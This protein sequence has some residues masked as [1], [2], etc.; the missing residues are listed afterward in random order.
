MKLNK[1]RSIFKTIGLLAALPL[2]VVFS[3]CKNVDLKK[4]NDQLLSGQLLDNQT[5]VAGLKQALE[6]STK[7]SVLQTSKKGGFSN[8]DLIRISTP[9]QLQKVSDTLNKL[10]MGKYVKQFETQMNRAAESASAE[11][12]QVFFASISQMSLTDGINILKGPDDA[13]TQ[14][15]QKTSTAQ[16]TQK[17]KPIITRSMSKIGFYDDYKTLLKTYDAIPFT[18]KPDLNIENYILDQTLN[19]LF[20]LVAKEEAKI[21]NDPAARVTELLQRVFSANE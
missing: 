20:T 15:F 17:F 21:R 19:G 11:A 7:N 2:L 14:F 12:K 13:A 10:G 4:I 5:I 6:V 18:T 3:G 16:L 8:N 9:Q 1:T